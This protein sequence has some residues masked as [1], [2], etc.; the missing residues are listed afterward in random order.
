[1]GIAHSHNAASV[2][3]LRLTLNAFSCTIDIPHSLHFE[4]ALVREFVLSA[5]KSTSNASSKSVSF[6]PTVTLSVTPSLPL[7]HLITPLSSRSKYRLLNC[8]V[9][10]PLCELE[11]FAAST[12]H[13]I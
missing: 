6:P 2:P 8:N 12:E 10:G 11:L 9:P 4:E 7:P 5:S 13:C 1:M 3:S